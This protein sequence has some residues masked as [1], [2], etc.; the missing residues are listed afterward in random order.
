M[1]GF[2]T[3]GKLQQFLFL[4]AQSPN[5]LPGNVNCTEFASLARP[6]QPALITLEGETTGDTPHH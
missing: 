1:R 4:F 3:G 2:R 6:G 5:L